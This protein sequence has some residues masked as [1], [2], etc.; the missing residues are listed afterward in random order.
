MQVQK[1]PAEMAF[2]K[3]RPTK[4]FSSGRKEQ[5]ATDTNTLMYLQKFLIWRSQAY[6]SKI[7]HRQTGAHTH[8]STILMCSL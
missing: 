2:D 6:L 3:K 5:K 8:R 7:T 4:Y 1:T